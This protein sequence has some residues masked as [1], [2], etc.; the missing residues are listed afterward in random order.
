MVLAQFDL[1][2]GEEDLPDSYQPRMREMTFNLATGE[3]TSRQL[4][5]VICEF[6]RVPDDLIGAH[7]LHACCL[8]FSH[9]ALLAS[10]QSPWPPIIIL[11]LAC[12]LAAY[13]SIHLPMHDL[14]RLTI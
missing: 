10:R 3:A 9:I 4:A 14:I 2:I 13:R 8:F 12:C 7:P 6:P 1:D 11:H 5:D